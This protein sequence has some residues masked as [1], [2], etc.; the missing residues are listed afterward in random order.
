L[1]QGWSQSSESSESSKAA[2]QQKELNFRN[3]LLLGDK[4]SPGL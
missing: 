1:G 4:K 3:P 2:K